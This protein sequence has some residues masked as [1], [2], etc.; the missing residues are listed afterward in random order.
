MNKDNIK[1]LAFSLGADFFGVADL[2]PFQGEITIPDDLLGP[3]KRALSMGVALNRD[4]IQG[5]VSG[6]TPIYS[7][8]Y[9][10]VNQLLDQIALRLSNTM[11]RQGVRTLPIPASQILDRDDY[12]GA[13]SHKSVARMAGLGWQGKSLLLVNPKVGPRIRLVTVL[14]DLEL[15]ADK[16]LE[17]GCGECRECQ[18][19]C[20]A[21]A[22]KGTPFG[23]GYGTRDQAWDMKACTD[24]LINDFGP[25]TGVTSLICGLCIRACPIGRRN[26]AY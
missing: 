21:G 15:P 7:H 12:L 19:A 2:E 11:Q 1:E 20:P 6:P 18:K 3:Y 23:L 24:K 16:P 9:Q 17:N 13:I 22:I 26:K 10:V 14:T 25:K 4:I 8:H 5:V